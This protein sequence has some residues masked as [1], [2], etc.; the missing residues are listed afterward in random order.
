M[1]SL[2]S[3][4]SCLY[5]RSF[6]KLY[7][8]FKV[9][10]QNVYHWLLSQPL[11]TSSYFLSSRLVSRRHIIGFEQFLSSVFLAKVISRSHSLDGLALFSPQLTSDVLDISNLLWM[12]IAKSLDNSRKGILAKGQMFPSWNFWVTHSPIP[13]RTRKGAADQRE[14]WVV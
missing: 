13:V 2:C 6:Q 14:T 7:F 10:S 12:F 8:C 3:L 1:F 11:S 9:N 4:W 5:S